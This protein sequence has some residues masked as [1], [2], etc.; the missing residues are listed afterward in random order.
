[1]R[2]LD[3]LAK[4]MAVYVADRNNNEQ[5]HRDADALMLDVLVVF[6]GYLND[7]ADI[8]DLERIAVLY[9]KATE[10]KWWYG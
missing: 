3:L 1:M 9:A 10:S 2:A 6:M 8:E 4:K 5:S 7:P